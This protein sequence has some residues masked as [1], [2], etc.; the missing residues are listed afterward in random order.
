MKK[1]LFSDSTALGLF[2]R[3]LLINGSPFSCFLEDLEN[4][5]CFW[6]TFIWD[7]QLSVDFRLS[8]EYAKL[9][10]A[11]L[12][13]LPCLLDWCLVFSEDTGRGGLAL[14]DDEGQGGLDLSE[15]LNLSLFACLDLSRNF[16]LPLL[17]WENLL[18]EEI[19]L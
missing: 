13:R 7:G 3:C 15:V 8:F 17:S 9:P 2:V 10:M 12:D 1:Y 16:C 18:S 4:V 5:E 11:F 19:C 14:S 6:R